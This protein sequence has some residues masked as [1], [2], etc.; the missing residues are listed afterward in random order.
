MSGP[1]QSKTPSRHPRRGGTPAASR[2][3]VQTA[4]F[5]AA[6]LLLALAPAASQ[7]QSPPSGHYGPTSVAPLAEKLLDA[8]VNIST[9]QT[10]KGPEGAPL[11]RVPKGAPFEEFFEDFFNRK[12]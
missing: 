8:V 5:G 12:G 2:R 4:V 3:V 11:P 1:L 10:V 9:S 6:G 7:T